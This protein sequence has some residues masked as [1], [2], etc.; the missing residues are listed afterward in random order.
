MLK[1]S[2]SS[3]FSTHV[4]IFDVVK[5]FIRRSVQRHIWYREHERVTQGKIGRIW[6]M[7]AELCFYLGEKHLSIEYYVER[8]IEP[9]STQ[10]P[11]FD[12]RPAF[13][14][15]VVDE[16]VLEQVFRVF[17]FA[18]VSIIPQMFQW[19]NTDAIW[20][21]QLTASLINKLKS[22]K[23][24]GSTCTAK[25]VVIQVCVKL[26]GLSVYLEVTKF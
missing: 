1:N 12:T 26:H 14:V 24:A 22:G 11:Q 6:W 20:S 21:W 10:R 4:R 3:Y 9:F 8:D 5:Q 7:F 23:G 25:C 19:S 16:V 2:S 15:F 17:W 13:L 18:L